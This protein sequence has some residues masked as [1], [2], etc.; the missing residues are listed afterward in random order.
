MKDS[1]RGHSVSGGRSVSNVASSGLSEGQHDDRNIGADPLMMHVKEEP[2]SDYDDEDDA[3]FSED[4][5]ESQGYSGTTDFVRQAPYDTRPFPDEEAV[6]RGNKMVVALPPPPSLQKRPSLKRKS[7]HPSAQRTS[8]TS[9]TDSVGV[10]EDVNSGDIGASGEGGV[11]ATKVLKNI[12]KSIPE[13]AMNLGTSSEIGDDNKP[14][15]GDEDWA[16]YMVRPQ[17]QKKKTRMELPLEKKIELIREYKKSPKPRQKAFAMKYGLGRS[18]VSDILKKSDFYMKQYEENADLNKR[19]FHNSC[20][21]EQLNRFMWSWYLEARARGIPVSGTLIQERSLKYAHELRMPDFK[22]S[23]GWLQSWKSRYSIKSFKVSSND[24]FR[25][26][27]DYVPN[28]PQDDSARIEVVP[29]VLDMPATGVAPP[30]PPGLTSGMSPGA[31]D[32]SKIGL[33]PSNLLYSEPPV[34]PDRD[35]AE[36]KTAYSGQEDT[37]PEK[38]EIDTVSEEEEDTNDADTEESEPGS[39]NNKTIKQDMTN[40][41]Y[42]LS[43]KNTDPP[44]TGDYPSPSSTSYLAQPVSSDYITEPVKNY[45]SQYKDYHHSSSTPDYHI[46]PREFDLHAKDYLDTQNEHFQ[47]PNADF[48]MHTTSFDP[49]GKTYNLGAPGDTQSH[50]FKVQASSFD[51]QQQQPSSSA[52]YRTPNPANY[53]T[54]SQ[55]FS[56]QPTDFQPQPKDPL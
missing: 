4:T 23:N 24:T 25:S 37:L 28:N 53:P 33:M 27:V 45:H 52:V 20:K 12:V 36:N 14:S 17:A 6:S 44:Q 19:R 9:E 13:M 51:G 54:P 43:E 10:N 5:S 40:K 2:M 21:F 22:A 41:E 1:G 11:D 26:R 50:H 39:P 55:H 35:I 49:Q 46:S 15:F 30:M 16:M 8:Q 32:C 42:S 48:H 34:F 38:P 47:P 18:T 56:L 29:H 3:S 31:Q 7:F